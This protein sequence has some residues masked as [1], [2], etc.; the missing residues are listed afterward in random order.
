MNKLTPDNFKEEARNNLIRYPIF[1][2]ELEQALSLPLNINKTITRHKNGSRG[3]NLRVLI[4]DCVTFFNYF[5]RSFGFF[6][7]SYL[8]GKNNEMGVNSIGKLFGC[9]EGEYD[10]TFYNNLIEE[11]GI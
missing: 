11:M 8:V 7:M 9:W 2:W 4:N 6:L 3:G 5:D 10:E 1:E